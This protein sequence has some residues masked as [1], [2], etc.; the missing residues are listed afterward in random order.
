MSCDFIRSEESLWED[1]GIGQCESIRSELNRELGKLIWKKTEKEVDPTNPDVLVILNLEKDR[2]EFEIRSLF[3][4]GG[5]KKLVRGI[6][7]TKWDKYEETV[8]DVIAAPVMLA[9]KGESHAMHAAG[10]ED[11]DARCL[12]FR[13]FVLEIKSPQKRK[14]DLKK[15]AA[16]IK[17][18]KKVE[19]SGLGFS[20]KKQV[21]L[22]K[23]MRNDK[24]YS[25]VAGFEKPVKKPEL[26]ERIRGCISQRTPIRVAHRR[27]DKI[28]KRRVKD[29]KWRRINNKK[30]EFQI[31]GEAGLYIKELV[32]GD[33]GRTTPSIAGLLKNP[34]VVHTLDVIKIWE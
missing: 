1:V 8:E 34:A 4:R 15:I 18:S 16:K 29:I 33:G 5:Y 2:T 10:R 7:Q 22:V 28:R 32:T 25:V 20:D 31:K 17:G 21:V 24:S 14:I 9:T 30:F 13:P 11:I 23:S 19:V 3:I 12:D 27:A 6:P 26:V